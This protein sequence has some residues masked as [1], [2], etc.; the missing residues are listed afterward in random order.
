M[1]EL[2]MSKHREEG[3]SEEGRNM[4]SGCLTCYES[5]CVCMHVRMSLCIMYV[6]HREEGIAKE[7]RNILNCFF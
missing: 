2:R 4:L 7:S 6:K 1:C 3:I 5:T